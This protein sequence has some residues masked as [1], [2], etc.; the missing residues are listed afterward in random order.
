MESMAQQQARR[1]KETQVGV[2]NLQAQQSAGMGKIDSA[3]PPQ[4]I[5]VQQPQQPQ[6]VYVQQQPGQQQQQPQPQV[7]YVQQPQQAPQQ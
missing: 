1:A 2:R 7:V 3:P 6:V 4:I 5:Y